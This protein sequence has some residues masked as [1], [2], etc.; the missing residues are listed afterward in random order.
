MAHEK[1]HAIEHKSGGADVLDISELTD[2][3]S[4]LHV[5]NTDTKLDEG[6]ANEVTAAQAKSAYTHVSSDG[7]DHTYINQDLRNTASPQ[8]ANVLVS[9]DPTLDDHLTRKSYV[10]QLI[11]G[12]EWQDS[13]KDRVSSEPSSP[14]DGDR[15]IALTAWG[16]GSN[17][18]IAEYDADTTSWTWISTVEGFACWVDDEDKQ[19]VFNGSIWAILSGSASHNDLSGLQGGQASEYY[20]LT[21][22]QHT[23]AVN[24]DAAKIQGQTVADPTS[25]EDGAYLRYDYSNSKFEYITDANVGT[26]IYRE[27]FVDGDLT[28]EKITITHNLCAVNPIVQVYDDEN[29]FITPNEITYVDLNTIELDFTGGTPLSGTYSVTVVGGMAFALF[30][31]ITT[32]TNGDL[33]DN[34][35]TITHNLATPWPIV[36]VYD[37]NDEIIVPNATT[38][39]D[40]NSIELDFTESTPLSGTYK[41]I[42]GG[43]S[44]T[45]VSTSLH[46]VDATAV[47]NLEKIR[48]NDGVTSSDYVEDYYFE[49]TL[50]DDST[51]NISL[52]ALATYRSFQIDF[53]LESNSKYETGHIMI[54]HND[55]NAFINVVRI[56]CGTEIGVTFNAIIDGSNVALVCVTSSVGGTTTSRF[57]VTRFQT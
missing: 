25:A 34:K 17:N 1:L 40:D 52:G 7:T 45:C 19:Y 50:S 21:S 36:Q 5:Q 10:D 22:A 12:L 33:T 26:A 47:L 51:N 14:S 3:S 15:Y 32:F 54:V 9:T 4:Y 8:F 57:K 55:S 56:D 28:D 29:K 53:S 27:T 46:N 18:D 38:Y 11:Q 30:R 23:L 6:G 24:R 16:T 43:G 35:I 48:I 31:Y 42:V 2:T 39:A 20:H 13:V 49:T 41:C 37:N 44:G